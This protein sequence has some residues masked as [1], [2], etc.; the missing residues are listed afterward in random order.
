MNFRTPRRSAA[1]TLIELL[2]VIAIIAILMSIL[3]PAIGIVKDQAN[4]TRARNDVVNIVAAVKQYNVEYGKYPIIE[5]PVADAT[6]DAV[7]GSEKAI[8][9]GS[10]I[11]NS[12]L[13]N[14]LRA[15][16]AG[17]NGSG[18]GGKGGGS[19][20]SND[21]RMNPRRVVFFEGRSVTNAASPKGGFLDRVESGNPDNK[22]SYYDP[23]G[24]QYTIIIDQNIDN[25]LNNPP[26]PYTDF[27]SPN[28]PRAGVG[29]FSLGKDNQLGNKGD[30]TYKNGTTASDDV[31]SWQ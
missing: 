17:I 12:E 7:C 21:H 20:S 23:W 16:A 25:L 22:G 14:T 29:A 6:K 9:G 28:E 15:I 31:A 18:G 5:D 4:R 13:F 1:F 3:F 30:K 10:P 11:K 2:T 26:L 19:G 27:A 8:S 24:E